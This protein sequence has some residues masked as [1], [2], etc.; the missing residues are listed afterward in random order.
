M[1]QGHL[2]AH[3]EMK[4]QAEQAIKERQQMYEQAEKGLRGFVERA[5]EP[6]SVTEEDVSATE[7]G[8]YKDKWD[9]EAR[10]MRAAMEGSKEWK[11]MI[12]E[13]V[14]AQGEDAAYSW[15]ENWIN[16]FYAG[17]NPDAIRWE[18]L[19]NSIEQALAQEAGKKNLV[20]TI[21]TKLAEERGITATSE[22]VLAALGMTG[23]LPPGMVAPAVGAGIMGQT[24]EAMAEQAS[25]MADAIIGPITEQFKSADMKEPAIAIVGQLNTAMRA[26]VRSFDWASEV[27]AAV[28]ASMD[29]EGKED[30]KNAGI[31]IGNA[32][33][34]GIYAAFEEADIVWTIVK[35]VMALINAESH[36]GG[37][38]G[39]SGHDK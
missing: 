19:L 20:E 36:Q 32:L 17:M 10:R 6:T 2:D 35:R 29:D 16:Q 8:A 38:G 31:M 12:P 39:G 30:L 3:S 11:S 23:M 5:I 7:R 27:N 1:V 25:G 26:E 15:G 21:M 14:W 24:P 18:P 28:K 22:Q 9:E 13:G 4:R 34:E 33:W 37:G